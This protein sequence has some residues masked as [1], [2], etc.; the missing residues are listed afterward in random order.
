MRSVIPKL[1][2]FSC[3]LR[4]SVFIGILIF[5]FGV[6][7]YCKSKSIA[8][9][10]VPVELQPSD[11]EIQ[12]LIDSSE[13]KTDLG[14]L[15][16]ALQLA[17]KAWDI[18]QKRGLESDL[19]V[20]ALNLAALYISKGDID[21]ARDLINKALESAAER[22]DPALEAE[23]LISLA[24]LRE[25][26]GDRKASLETNERALQKAKTGK[27]LYVQAR[28][29][30]EIGRMR[31]TAGAL[32]EARTSLNAALDID[33]A[34]HYSLEALHRV[35]WVYS[36]L[37]ESEQNVPSAIKTLEEARQLAK[38]TGNSYAEFA[39]TNSLGFAYIAEGDLK[40]GLE[41]LDVTST[42]RSLLLEFSRL[43]T[44]AFAYQAGHLPDKSAETWNALLAKAKSVG[45]QYF[46]AES[47]QKLG[48][49]NRDK[50]EPEMAFAYYETA[51]RSFRSV[52]NKVNLLQ[53]LTSEIPLLQA[54]KA[55][56][57][58]AQIYAETLQLVQEQKGKASN[59]LQFALYLGWSFFYKQQKDWVKEIENLGKAEELIPISLG[60]PP[61]ESVT[62]TLMSMWIDHAVASD[63][64]HSP[65]FSVL[66][67]EQAF[68]CALQ[69][70]DEKAQQTVM[71]AIVST[72]QNLGEYRDLQS[73]CD[74]GKL[75]SCL[76]SALSLNTL[77]LLN[78]QWRNKW[79][80]E[81]GLA[82]SKIT[83]LPEQLLNSSDGVPYLLRL[84]S[85]I[86]PIQSGSR[87]VIEMA[88][89]RHYLFASDDFASAKHVL[90]DAESLL[91][92]AQTAPNAA[93]EGL[94]ALVTVHCW[95][96]L[97]LG[98][99]GEPDAAEQKLSV[100]LQ[101]AKAMGTEQAMK[102]AQ[103][104]S[105]SVRL[106]ANNPAA[107]EP[108]QYWIQAL[109]DSPDLRRSYAYSLA[110]GRDFEGAIR[111]MSLAATMFEKAKQEPDLAESYVSLAVYYEMKKEP[112]YE[113]AIECLNKALVIAQTLHDEKEQAKIDMDL[114][115]G[116]EAKGRIDSASRSFTT[117]QQLATKEGNWEV[118]ARSLWGLAEIAEKK[119]ENDAEILYGRAAT[120]FSK[121]GIPD[122]ESQVLVRKAN[123]LRDKGH[124]EEAIRVLLNARDLAEQSKNNISGVI[125]YSGLG[126]AYEA[127]GQYPNAILAFGAARDKAAADK[128]VPSQAYSD[129]AIAG[130]C[131]IIGEW[132]AALEHALSAVNE[133]KSVGD[134]SGELY[135]YSELIAVYTERSSELKD[136]QKASSIYREASS[137]KTFQS[138][139]ISISMQM[140]EMYTQTKQYKEWIDTATS[141]LSQCTAEKDNVCVAHARLSLSEAYSIKGDRK[142]SQEELKRARPLVDAAHD[143]YLS[144]R[145][146]YVRARVERD[147]GDLQ[148]AVKDYSDVVDM[149]G[150]LQGGS[151]TEESSAVF[152]N[153]SFI[154]D[155]LI[156]TLYQQSS[157]QPLHLN[158]FA[159]LALQTAEANKGQ[160]FDK[161]WGTR[162]S[163]ALRGR[164]L[165]TAD[166][167]KET[168][169]QVRKAKLSA[170]LH[171]VLAAGSQSSRPAEQI[172]SEV[173][174]V[175]RQLAGFV[176]DL[177]AKYPSY[178]M[179]RYPRPLEVKDVPLLSGELLIE[180]RVT[181][182]EAYVWFLTKRV[183]GH[184]EI[185]QF[186]SVPKGREWFRTEVERIKRG[187]SEA[188]L[189]G[190]DPNTVQEL[191]NTLF[192]IFAYTSLRRAK[193]II[194][195]PDDA[196]ALIPL[197]MLS[198]EAAKGVYPL[199]E[200]PTTYYPSTEAMMMSRA[201]KSGGPWPSQ[202]FGIG[203]P[204][205]AQSDPRW[206]AAAEISPESHN[207]APETPSTV[208]S[209]LRSAGVSFERLPGT[210]VEVHGIAELI[211]RDGGKVDIRLGIEANRKQFLETDLRKYR[212]LHFATHGLLPVDSGLREPAL[213]FS[214]N[215]DSADMFL[216][217]SQVLDL[218][219]QSE[220]VVLSACNTG[221][222][223]LSKSDGVHNLGRAFLAAGAS[224]VV[225]S[226]WEVADNS[227]A[228]F[229]QELYKSI[230]KGDPKNVALMHARLA[231]I[232]QGFDQP[233][234]WAPFILTGE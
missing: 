100:C 72:E 81:R 21:V 20:A 26:S 39:A 25:I 94:N 163:D 128:N 52:G 32:S 90:A 74:S 143:Y 43:E 7:A 14:D 232:H 64:L 30:G 113:T 219:L 170:E 83:A 56:D 136:F 38:T 3:I 79:Q 46:I 173:S 196:L 101:E 189:G 49:I 150:A 1:D 197:E 34:N 184:S 104:T 55:D 99:T 61:D 199:A 53:V 141:L 139:S 132:T 4:F 123:I 28:A 174:D 153:Y 192:P 112:D 200:V 165:S 16:G 187:I 54:A 227:T 69:L 206:D 98:R 84:L 29:F 145:F 130:V 167:E 18:C 116:Y 172:R 229:M 224:S 124:G 33:K 122:A 80:V 109:G 85:V 168:E 120:L 57:K 205:T 88:L 102:F 140:V 24:A 149:I 41:L 35:Y 180:C 65:Y 95:L 159:A 148:A 142:A 8:R 152:E 75:Q 70:K 207:A 215:G 190:Y 154:F 92:N 157:R 96:A 91:A 36:M 166:R 17:T 127:A 218:Q 160:S 151:N 223:K 12:A 44:L 15:E 66:A 169:L 195:V 194:Y 13:D 71:S 201:A 106:L 59:D 73:V 87:I 202:L 233:F 93:A 209:T 108:T 50:H 183:D 10:E 137:L 63:H 158:D 226:M 76:E 117:A 78:E 176:S 51:A 9:Q 47:A 211:E 11:P 86:S 62:K 110:T 19:P 125:A 220:M 216:Q 111:E 58:A 22:S 164:L 82:I 147:A 221:S 68:Q 179:I 177:R 203:D 188:Q 162:F 31:L 40:R 234:F 198:P 45:N 67:L 182:D 89:A 5:A 146:L 131:Q 138:K 114:G 115:F 210:A 204:I 6:P 175:D 230:L 156:S 231:L 97:A 225:V 217:L 129:A 178:T 107:A 208:A 60:H 103:A 126:Y 119:Q 214:F 134:E 181:E 23:V 186:Y 161:V 133:F 171:D 144:G 27:S 118:A 193:A 105:A 222:G 2:G 185:S 228:L 48:D 42:N 212:F 155:E 135:A 121:A 213:L 37:L 77:E 191:T